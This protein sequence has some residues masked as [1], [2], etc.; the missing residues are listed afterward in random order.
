LRSTRSSMASTEATCSSDVPRCMFAPGS[1]DIGRAPVRVTQWGCNSRASAAA[2]AAGP[3]PRCS[4]PMDARWPAKCIAVA[5]HR[6]LASVQRAGD[7]AC[8]TRG[9]VSPARARCE[10][11][12]GQALSD[13]RRAI[14]PSSRER[15]RR[16]R[17]GGEAEGEMDRSSWRLGHV[18]ATR[19]A[20]DEGSRFGR[21]VVEHH[22]GSLWD[23]AVVQLD[24][25]RRR[26]EEPEDG[27]S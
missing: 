25:P 23:H 11:E 13:W 18:E 1:L 16:G 20:E 26:A 27:E 15:R 6:L 10:D 3:P 2:S 19:V 8:P 17:R 5:H 24:S 21:S 12:S 22:L 7:F 14:R 9:R 4:G